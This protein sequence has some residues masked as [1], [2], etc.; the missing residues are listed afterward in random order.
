MSRVS[1]RAGITAYFTA[2]AAAGDL[3]YVGTIYPAR[4]VV[5]NEQAYTQTLLGEAVAQT[6]G[7]SSAVLVVNLPTT[8]RQ[9]RADTGRGATNDTEIHEAVIEVFFACSSGQG[10]VAQQDYDEIIDSMITLIRADATFGGTAWSAAEYAAGIDH[11]QDPPFTL[12]DGSTVAIVGTVDFQFWIWV[13][14]NTT[15]P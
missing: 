15:P 5:M 12:A 10:L 1:A 6:T 13:D 9:R 4:P 14:G 3:P 7:G 8:R 11:H 2:G